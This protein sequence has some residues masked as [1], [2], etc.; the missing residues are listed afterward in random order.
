MRGQGAGWPESTE[1]SAPLAMSADDRE[2]DRPY[3][4]SWAASWAGP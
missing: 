1:S 4:G 2:A 3:L